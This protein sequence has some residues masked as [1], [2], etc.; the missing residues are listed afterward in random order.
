[1]KIFRYAVVGGVAAAIDFAVFAVFAKGLG[2]NYLWVG[3]YGFVLA[4]AIN[5]I[6]SI[7][8]VFAS[9]VRFGRNTEIFL[10][11]AISAVGLSLNQLILYILIGQLGTEMLL[12]KIVA[13]GMVFLWNYSARNH[14]IFKE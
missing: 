1:M 5:Y 14:F 7:R 13:T 9:G 10:V 11:F 6:L 3:F 2:F 4:T 8:H 12:S